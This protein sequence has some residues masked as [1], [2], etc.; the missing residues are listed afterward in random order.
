[1]GGPGAGYIR[2]SSGSRLRTAEVA[3]GCGSTSRG[4]EA[5]LL[6]RLQGPDRRSR[7]GVPL[8]PCSPRFPRRTTLPPPPHSAQR[9]SPLHVRPTLHRGLSRLRVAVTPHPE[10]CGLRGPAPQNQWPAAPRNELAPGCDS[11]SRG[12]PGNR[13]A[14][15]DRRTQ[16]RAA[17][18]HRRD[19]D[20]CTDLVRWRQAPLRCTQWRSCRCVWPLRRTRRK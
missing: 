4:P 14:R 1:M 11:A 10:A 19:S 3:P 16:D 13:A 9:S 17:A 12:L 20:A 7:T 8:A 15:E 18:G 2:P 5:D 6:S